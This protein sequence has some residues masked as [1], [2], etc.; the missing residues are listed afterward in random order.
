MGDDMLVESGLFLEKNNE[1]YELLVPDNHLL[2]ELASM[3]DFSFIF[4]ELRDKYCL[5]NGRT[6]VNPITLFKYIILK[7]IYKLSDV[8]VV[9][10]TLYDLSFKFFLEMDPR[11]TKLIDPSLLTKFRRERLKDE[12]LLDL[13]ISKSLEIARN[14]GIALGNKM[15]IDSTHSVS[16]YNCKSPHKALMDMAKSIRKHMYQSD[17]GIKNELPAKPK[18]GDSLEMIMD[19][20]KKLDDYIKEHPKFSR[21]P[22]ISEPSSY[23]REICEDHEL[24]GLE[25]SKEAEAALGHKSRDT[26]FYGFKN[27]I[28][29]NEDGIV[30]AATI[31]TGEKHDGK[32]LETLVEKAESNGVEVSVVIGDGAYSEQ[33]NLKLAEEKNFKL[34]SNLSQ[35][36]IEGKHKVK[37]EFNKDAQMYVCPAGHLATRKQTIKETKVGGYTYGKTTTYFFDIEKCKYCPKKE[38]CYKAGARTK[39]YS[40]TSRTDIHQK[41]KEFMETVEYKTEMKQRYKIEQ[42]NAHLKKDLGLGI[43]NGLGLLSMNIQTSAVIFVSNLQK[44][45]KLK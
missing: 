44:I 13:L 28:G 12:N 5:N 19:Y 22:G 18:D 17:E 40:V 7:N 23:L 21:M 31:T 34:I 11:E 42:L 3:V 10:R 15:I 24:T 16:S 9:N 26:K 39:S 41:Q 43:T 25:L 4:E 20:C 2:K 29:I 30:I 35:Q 38:G 14:H 33:D 8:A 1:L 6:A 27:H 36:V 32:Q 37:F 45:R